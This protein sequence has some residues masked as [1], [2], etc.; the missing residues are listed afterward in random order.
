MAFFQVLMVPMLIL[1]PFYVDQCL[2]AGPQWY[3][4]LLAASGLGSLVGYGIGGAVK[5]APILSSRITVSAMVLMSLS[6]A[7]LALVIN[8]WTALWIIAGIGTMDGFIGVKLLTALQLA[9]PRE[10]RD[11]SLEYCSPLPEVWCL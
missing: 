6:L 9:T 1:F 2:H 8:R 4:F 10:V 7:L 3:G 11:E 5:L